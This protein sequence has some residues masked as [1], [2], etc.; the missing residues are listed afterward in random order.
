MAELSQD[1][2]RAALRTVRDPD[3]SRDIVAAG[4]VFTMD[5]DAAVSA[6]EVDVQMVHGGWENIVARQDLEDAALTAKLNSVRPWLLVHLVFAV[7]TPFLWATTI[8]LALKR[9]GANPVPGPHSR[10]HS[11]LGWASTLDITLTSITGLAFYY[12]AF[13]Q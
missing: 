13:V 7:T 10:L 11:L 5:S 3:S 4:M 8:V 2:L 1:T 12:V 6:F 9:F